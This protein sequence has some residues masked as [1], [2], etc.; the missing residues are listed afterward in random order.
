LVNLRQRLPEGIKNIYDPQNN[1]FTPRIAIITSDTTTHTKVEFPR[2]AEL[3][4]ADPL[5][6]NPAKFVRASM[7][8]PFFF[9]PLCINDIPDAGIS[10]HPKWDEHAKY[11]G[12][13]PERVRFVDG[14]MLSNF[15]INVF[16][17]KDNQVP[18]MPSFGVR[19]STYRKN[20]SKT[21]SVFGISGAMVSTMRQIHD[22][23]F[24]LQN[25]DYNKLICRIDADNEFNWLNFNM[26]RE[27]QILLFTLGARKGLEF[28]ENFNWEEYKEIRRTGKDIKPSR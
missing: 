14:G 1:T 12:E 5:S 19:L 10:D 3:Y 9:E 21:D 27:E 24:L 17:R 15:P 6:V 26:S 2:M 28:I 18:R 11:F 20:Y 23:D 8:I 7:A 4:W 22:Y 16:H 25:P 13:V